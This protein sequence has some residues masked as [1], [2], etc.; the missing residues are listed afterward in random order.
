[1][2]NLESI[3][4]MRKTL[5]AMNSDLT[6]Y[7]GKKEHQRYLDSLRHYKKILNNYIIRASQE[8]DLSIDKSQDIINSFSP[9]LPDGR[10]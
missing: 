3:I 1:M 2:N 10:C 5:C 7:S 6:P 4:E 8:L 9:P